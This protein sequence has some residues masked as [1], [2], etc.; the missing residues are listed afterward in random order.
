MSFLI[1]IEPAQTRL[2]RPMDS[3]YFNRH[4]KFC[5]N[6]LWSTLNT[7]IIFW[8]AYSPPFPYCVR[9]TRKICFGA[10]GFVV[11]SVNMK[12][13]QSWPTLC[14]PRDYRVHGILH[15]RKLEWIAFPFS[16]GSSWPRNWPRVY[17]IADGLFT[18][19]AIKDANT[20]FLLALHPPLSAILTGNYM[21]IAGGS[22]KSCV[23]VCVCVCVFV[24]C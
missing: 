3:I 9:Y 17:H 21:E 2:C 7:L 11:K 14:K 23:C 5:N 18:N 6:S 24:R 8:Y 4:S 20:M 22:S 16:K 12:V 19:W 13:T 15:A 10:H 1:S